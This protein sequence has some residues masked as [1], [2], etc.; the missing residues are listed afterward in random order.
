[1]INARLG[2]VCDLKVYKNNASIRLPNCVK[3]NADTKTIEDRKIKPI[4]GTPLVN[5]LISDNVDA[6]PD[7]SDFISFQKMCPITD[8]G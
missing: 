5:F 2:A 7:Y 3:I 8:A 1:L 4:T 6:L